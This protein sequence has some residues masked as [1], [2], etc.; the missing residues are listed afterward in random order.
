MTI[1]TIQF[2]N[3]SSNP[4]RSPVPTYSQ[5]LFQ[6]PP[7]SSLRQPLIYFLFLEI[8]PFWTLRLNGIILWVVFCIWLLSLSIMFLRLIYVAACLSTSFLFIVKQ[9]YFLW[10]YHILFTHSPPVDGYPGCFIVLKN[11][12]LN[13]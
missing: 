13:V 6:S 9:Y 2:Q 8:C 12:F 5:S 4:I 11:D 3:I 1:T 7:S 10:L